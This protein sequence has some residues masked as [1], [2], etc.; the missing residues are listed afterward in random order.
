MTAS[1]LEACF[2]AVDD[3]TADL[4]FRADDYG[5]KMCLAILADLDRET[6]K[7]RAHFVEAATR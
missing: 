5:P 1:E 6:A 4:K 7:L 3:L 2:V